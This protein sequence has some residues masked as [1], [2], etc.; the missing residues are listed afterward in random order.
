VAGKGM[1]DEFHD[2]IAHE[3][4]KDF[5]RRKHNSKPRTTNE[6]P[7]VKSMKRFFDNNRRIAGWF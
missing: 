1:A 6:K 3:D 2:R 5:N 4:R 7:S